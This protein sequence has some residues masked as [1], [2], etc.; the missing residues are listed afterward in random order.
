MG[1]YDHCTNP[2]CLTVGPHDIPQ[3]CK[4]AAVPGRKYPVKENL[5]LTRVWCC[6][7]PINEDHVE[8]CPF[9]PAPDDVWSEGLGRTVKVPVG[10]VMHDP[11][12]QRYEDCPACVANGKRELTPL[13]SSY[14]RQ[15]TCCD[16]T[17]AQVH[18]SLCPHYMMYGN[19]LFHAY[20]ESVVLA[21]RQQREGRVTAHGN[22]RCG[23][24]FLRSG[25]TEPMPHKPGEYDSCTYPGAAV[26][27]WENGALPMFGRQ[28]GK[29]RFA[30]TV[31]RFVR[32]YYA[33]GQVITVRLPKRL[34]EPP[35]VLQQHDQRAEDATYEN[36][37]RMHRD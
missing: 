6:Q 12:A 4:F 15:R 26:A 3:Q 28:G 11:K 5:L 27:G 19:G 35:V 17:S 20:M 7:T 32:T 18:S 16:T 22:C 24:V 8:G 13:E 33:P 29:Q 1:E 2:V 10:A 37:F 34:T 31:E 23:A 25:D 30:E 36:E 21:E 9:R 14:G